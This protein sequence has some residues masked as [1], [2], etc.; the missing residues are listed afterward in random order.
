MKNAACSIRQFCTLHFSFLT[1]HFIAQSQCRASLAS[2][3]IS[4]KAEYALRAVLAMSRAQMGTVFSIQS[5]SEAEQIPLK[6]LEQILLIM[7]KGGVLLSKRGA[8]GGY[9]LARPAERI[10]VGEVLELVDGPLEIIPLG[11][12][13]SPGLAG[14]FAELK[15]SVQ[16]WLAD[17][18]IADVLQRDQ[19]RGAM[20]FEI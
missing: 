1:L 5:L 19:A 13:V 4:R 18:S 14:V 12:L 10:S 16:S 3:K 8:G 7:R 20:S 11:A 17:T 2:M 6:F 15:V 9:Q